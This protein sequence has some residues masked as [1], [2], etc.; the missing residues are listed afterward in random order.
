[1]LQYNRVDVVTENVMLTL[2]LEVCSRFVAVLEKTGTP[3]LCSLW[4]VTPELDG[5][6]NNVNV[7]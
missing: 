5:R 6:N 2:I 3:L 1:M 7:T 4:D